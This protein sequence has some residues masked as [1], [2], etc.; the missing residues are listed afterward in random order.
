MS[1]LR[2]LGHGDIGVPQGS[3]G[4]LPL[5]CVRPRSWECRFKMWV[6]QLSDLSFTEKSRQMKS[7]RPMKIREHG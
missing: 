7:S 3:H 2:D 1:S 4:I 6:F 5:V